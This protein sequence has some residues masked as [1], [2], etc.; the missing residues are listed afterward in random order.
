M[1]KKLIILLLLL[2]WLSMLLQS[3][4]PQQSMRGFEASAT[5]ASSHI[6][7]IV[8]TSITS[9]ASSIIE[10]LI[11]ELLLICKW[12][13]SLYKISYITI[14]T[15]KIANDAI[16]SV[17][18]A[19][20]CYFFW[21]STR[22]YLLGVRHR[23][24]LMPKKCDVTWLEAYPFIQLPESKRKVSWVVKMSFFVTQIGC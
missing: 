16:T 14:Y 5:S 2:L 7:P 13:E 19:V 4:Y 11:Q 10:S 20:C 9:L 21:H 3:L 23:V 15:I 22:F 1:L 17:H 8:N 24:F 6:A 12:S 18:C